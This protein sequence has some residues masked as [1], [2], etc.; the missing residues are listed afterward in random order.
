MS[1]PG[2][3]ECKELVSD[4]SSPATLAGANGS[5][6]SFTDTSFPDTIMHQRI[7]CHNLIQAFLLNCFPFDWRPASQSW[8][9]LLSELPTTVEALEISG[10]AAA[11]SALGHMFHDDALVKQGLKYYTRGLHQLQRALHD[12][13]LMRD[14]GTLAA[15]MALSLYEALECPNLGS[16][17]YFNH[18][19]GLI[20]LIQ[21]RGQDV[22]CS[23]PGHKLFRGVRVPGVGLI[24]LHEHFFVG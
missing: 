17:G 22:H 8:I 16:E 6:R 12:P 7:E 10:A 23:G 9:Y 1:P 15:C 2:T 14:D 11:A 19:H 18:C 5:P 20:A 4:K 24:K 21:S 3:T 13:R